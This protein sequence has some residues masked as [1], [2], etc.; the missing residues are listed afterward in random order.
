[1]PNGSLE[2]YLYNPADSNPNLLS[3]ERR[4]KI[5]TGVASALH[6]LHNE[7]DEKVVHRD[8]KASNIMLESDF[9]PR[10]GD[11]G[12]ARILDNGMTSYAEQGLLGVPGTRGYVAPECLHTGKA[13]PESDVYGFGAVVLEVVCGK[14]PGVPISV[15]QDYFPLV[16]W[17]WKLHREGDILNAVDEQLKD[18]YV[19]EEAKRLLLL[20]LACSHPTASERPNTQAIVQIIAGNSPVP[21]VPPFKPTFTWPSA[22]NSATNTA[23][24]LLSIKSILNSE[25]ILTDLHMTSSPL[26]SE[27]V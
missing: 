7:Y 4:F 1:M 2:K 5:V 21:Y 24:S 10:L 19:G 13:T 22:G 15:E 16:D 9:T 18:E 26:L 27:S 17:V 14:N 23:E 6:Y 11:F 12:L 8:L 25:V 20:G 3:W